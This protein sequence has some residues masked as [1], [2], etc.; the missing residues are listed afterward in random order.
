MKHSLLEKLGTTARRDSFTAK[1][2]ITINGLLLLFAI[3]LM[4]TQLSWGQVN[5]VTWNFTTSITSAAYATNTTNQNSARSTGLTGPTLSLISFNGTGIAGVTGN[6]LH[7]T[8]GW[9]TTQDNSKYIE[10]SVTLAA[11]Q[12]FNDATMSLAIAS[13]VSSITTAPRNYQVQYGWGPSPTFTAVSGSNAA[14]VSTSGGTVTTLNTASTNNTA[15]I[16]APGNATSTILK[17]RLI[18]YGSTSSTG[19]IQ[20]HTIALTSASLPVT[21]SSSPT[22]T[23]DATTNTVDNSIDITFTDDSA[24]RTA[25]TAVK[26]G[27]TTLTSG[28]DYDLTA[29]NLQL[30]PSGLNVLLTTPGS[31]SVTVV[32]TGYTDATVTQVINAGAPTANSTATI[33]AALAPNTS[34]TITCTAKD[35]YNNLVSGYTFAYDVTLTNNNSTTA[36]SYTINSSPFT[37]TSTSGNSLSAT[38]NASGVATFT[39]ALPATI[40]PSDGISVQVQLNDDATNV[41]SAFTFAQLASQTITF[42]SLSP[43]TYGDA[44]FG[45]TA[46][47]SSTLPVSYTSSNIAVATV[48]GSTVTIVGAGSTNITVSQAG[49]GSYNAAED[50]IQSL[51]VNAIALTIP[52]AVAASR[53]YNTLLTTNITGTLTG[54]INSDDVTF[55]GTLKGTFADA[56]VANG[57]AVTSACTLAGTKAGNYSLTQPT[58]LTANIT[59]ASQTITFGV[60]ANKTTVDS[61][62]ALLATASSAL[63]VTYVSSNTAVATVSGSTVTIVGA[64]STTITASQIGDANYAAA[65]PVDQVLLVNP[66]VYLNQFTG[67]ADCPTNGNVPSVLTNVSGSPLTRS[68]IVCTNLANL[69]NSTTLNNSAS[70]NDA[71]YIEFSATAVS[72]YRLNLT[73]FSFYRQGSGTAPNSL[74]VRYSTDGF[75]TSTSWGAAPAT[76]TSG[77]VATWDFADFSSANAGTVTFRIYPYGTQRADLAVTA[78]ASTGTFRLDDITINGNITAVTSWNG[79]AWSNGAP[80]SSLD[81]IISGNLATSTDLICDDLTINSGMSL[82]IGAGNKL[83][84]S[85]NLINNGTLIFKSNATNTAMFDVFNGSQSGNGLVTVE[86]YIPAKR[87]WRALT[88]PLKGSDTSIFSQWQNNGTVTAGT[89]VELWGPGGTGSGSTSNGLEVG[90]NNSILQYDNSSAGAWAAVTDTKT[91]NLFTTN[92]NNAF[93]IFPTGGYGSGYISSSVPATETTLKATG[94]LITGDVPYSSLPNT[95]HTLIGNPYASPIDLNSI[96]D[97]NTT[98][99]KFFWV[100]D[101]KGANQ[102]TYNTFDAAANTYTFTNVSYSNSTVIQSGQAFFVKALT[103][104]TGSFTI[105]E[106]NKST[107]SSNAVFRTAAPELLRVGLY[108]QINTEWSG[109]DGAM[110]VLLPNANTNQTAN[111]MANGTENVAFTKNDLLFAS[112]HHLPLVASDVLNV[113]VW[114]TIAGTNYKLKINTEQF[115][116]TNLNATLED[117]FTNSRTPLTLNGTAVEYPFAVTTEAASTGNRF[118]IVFENSA[119]GI[120]N[121]KASGI[122]ILPNPITGDTFQVNLGTLSTGTYSYSISNALGQEVENGSINNVTQNSNYT[123]KF[124][125]STANGMYIMKV[126][127]TDNSVFTAKIIKQ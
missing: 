2:K 1:S 38:T 6:T 122:S 43:V 126:T 81:A 50:V 90:S 67:I 91:T 118:R 37:A 72:G 125:Y 110:T 69:F 57:I 115:T 29:G 14:A 100:W 11:G 42:G 79:T 48:T 104:Q 3:L 83:T 61:P 16:P 94:Q 34:R 21:G 92:A 20:F 85:G 75:A 46:T 103:G 40:D 109:R 62:F 60:L 116:T 127:G 65:T 102:G 8:T 112:E 70:V 31:K 19:N 105:S 49:D 47:A 63:A 12:K 77:T 39:A 99:E 84:V 13:G 121:P 82:E 120:N 4:N 76:P 96:L 26:I 108:K 106:S 73:S 52:D 28:T 101:P 15:I 86:R 93:M 33:S 10:F 97:A 113:K 117:L 89:G 66:V 32:A 55:D 30:K 36:E 58:G 27:T 111:K 53:A 59:Q 114:N 123:V 78:A 25:V 17:I 23:A 71:S 7:R 24:W 5:Y 51:T 119:L 18:A 35:Q 22:L 56:N 74:E 107:G 80:T 87:A 45:L 98:L 54:V 9:P 41:G 124:K 95:S 68:T 88:A 64:G 44:T